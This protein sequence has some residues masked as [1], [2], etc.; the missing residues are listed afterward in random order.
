MNYTELQARVL[1]IAH[2][3]DLVAQMEGFASDAN[4]KINRRFSLALVAPSTT[5][6]TNEVLTSYPLLYVYAALTSLYDYLDNTDD[7]DRYQEK[8]NIEADAQNVSQSGAVT[9]P[10]TIDDVPPAIVRV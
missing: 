7:A 3:G 6:A 4:E 8:W 9:D 5:N 2:R 1:G 10:W